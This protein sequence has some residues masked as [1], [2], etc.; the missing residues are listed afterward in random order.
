MFIEGK[1]LRAAGSHSVM[2]E[3][4]GSHPKIFI[5]GAPRSGT[6]ILLFAMKDVFGLPGFGESHVMPAINQ[7]VHSFYKYIEQY[8]GVD[9]SVLAEIMLPRV[10]LDEIKKPLF[11]YVR[12]LYGKTFPGG[13]WVDKTPSPPGIF[14]LPLAEEIFPDARLIVMKR[15]GIEVVS[16]HVKK[17]S[18]RFETACD[19]WVSAMTG[20]ER[21]RPLCKNLLVVDQFDFFNATD[22]VAIDISAHVGLPEKAIE[23][24]RYLKT[25]RVESSSAHDWSRR[26]R[27]DDLP[28]T[29]QQREV[30]R[31]RC[32]HMMVTVGYEM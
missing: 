8:K 30:F 31:A 26:L 5:A 32:G 15:T 12:E 27:L 16:S 7:M 22:S 17:F 2:I 24:G 23:L 25:Q 13:N 10:S 20:L 9:K 1:G 4:S 18:S 28:W 6:S 29:E 3:P 14:A 21:I 19:I 11:G